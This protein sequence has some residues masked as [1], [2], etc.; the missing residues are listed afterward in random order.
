VEYQDIAELFYETM[1]KL[2]AEIVDIHRL[3]NP[4]LWQFYQVLVPHSSFSEL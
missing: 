1:T 2:D 4:V 3:E